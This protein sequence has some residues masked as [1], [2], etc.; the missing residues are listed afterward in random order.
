MRTDCIGAYGN[1]KIVTPNLDFLAN[2]GINLLDCYSQSPLCMPSRSSFMTGMYPQQTGVVNNGYTLPDHYPTT[3]PRMMK[4]AGYHTAQVGKLHLQPHENH[5]METKERN[6]YGFDVSY[7]SES[8]GCYEDAWVKWLRGRYPEHEAE[9]RIP[10]VYDRTDDEKKGKELNAPWQASHSGWVTQVSSQYLK[11]RKSSKQFMHLGFHNPHPPLNPTKE[12]FAPY[13]EMELDVPVS[14]RE[15]LDKP[16]P[17]SSLLQSRQ[18][19]TEEDMREY[20]RYFYALVTEMDLAIGTLLDSLR[21]EDML[22]DT[23]LVFSSDHGD[24]L[25]D[26]G[27]TH[28]GPHFYD[29]VMH[30]PLILFWPAGLGSK[31]RDVRGFVENVD[32]LP[33]LIE[34]GGGI[35][36]VTMSGRSHAELLRGE[37]DAALRED[38]FAFYGP[39]WVML[40]NERYKYIRYNSVYAEVLYDL[41]LPDREVVNVAERPEYR[42]VLHGMRERMLARTLEASRTTLTRNYSW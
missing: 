6:T 42:D 31:R 39:D 38:V 13:R 25:G 21:A 10:R 9:L 30:T 19:W 16:K 14:D 34:L 27:L 8:R 35:V 28:K 3:A 1:E 20:K 37:T 41:D 15:W 29:E 23:L 32:I 2:H 36:P 24:M 33:T 11:A 12:A 17:L 7:L 40:R 5:D 22:D 4:Q 26:H 18:D